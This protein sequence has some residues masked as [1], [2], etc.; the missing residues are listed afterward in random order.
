M[1]GNVLHTVYPYSSCVL[2]PYATEF[3]DLPE[4]IAPNEGDDK[5]PDITPDNQRM[6]VNKKQAKRAFKY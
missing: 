1:V 2:A 6:K 5:R 4:T 3:N